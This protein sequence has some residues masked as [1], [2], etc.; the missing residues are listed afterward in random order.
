MEDLLY[1]D[2]PEHLDFLAIYFAN[3]ITKLGKKL[4]FRQRIIST[5]TVFFRRF[6]LKNSYCETD[7]FIVIAACCY[8]AAKAE[9]S[10][11]HIKVIVAE[12]KALFS[13]ENYN[14]KNF[15]SDNAKI[16]EMEFYL[17]DDLE[18]DLIVFHPYRTLLS[19]CKK[20]ADSDASSN[21]EEGETEDPG[22]GID[23]GQRYWGTGD[24]QLELTPAA[25]QTSWS[26]VNDTYRSQL[27]LLHPPHLIAIAAIYLT[28]ILHP[29]ARPEPSQPSDQGSLA[30]NSPDHSNPVKQPR[31]SSRQANHASLAAPVSP[32]KPQDPIAFLS[33]LNVSL[34]LIA[35]IAQEI[36]SLYT[37][38]DQYKEDVSPD[39]S[40]LARELTNSP[41]P[42]GSSPKKSG[43]NS[44][45]ESVRASTSGA[46]TPGADG[47]DEPA[48]TVNVADGNF[49]TP[50]FLSSVLRKM[51]EAR[52]MDIPPATPTTT[53]RSVA[54]N[55][56][57]ERTQAVG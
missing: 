22:I 34:P 28:F 5:A 15:S 32:K 31:R 3:A 29:P 48:E 45:T 39:A 50:S 41:M 10:P 11:V 18:C 56:R 53:A 55:K 54:V 9:E 16:A 33:E 37:L 8:V 36:I 20:E 42:F 1:V 44:R 7:P 21:S 13:Q 49:I 46:G 40:K 47:R 51:R 24:G 57:L 43:S 19:L 25:L 30:E 26:I 27:C 2:D 6:Y 38:W 4:Q 14:V 35:T 23:D 12:S 52:L 17:V